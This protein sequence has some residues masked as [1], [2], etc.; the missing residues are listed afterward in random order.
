MIITHFVAKISLTYNGGF[1]IFLLPECNFLSINYQNLFWRISWKSCSTRNQ[2]PSSACRQDPTT[3]PASSWK[4]SSGGYLGRIFGINPRS[5]DLH[6]DGIKMYKDVGE[7][8]VIPD[9]VF[10]LIPARFIPD[11]IDSCGKAGVKWMAILSGGFNETGEEGKKLSDLVLQ[12]ARQYGI[13]FVGPN[14]VTVANTANG[15]CLPFVPSFSPPKGGC[16][17]SPR[18][19]V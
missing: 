3:S 18:A 8:P 5:S 2:S 7:L 11:A 13:R 4:T 12:K 14:G 16:R 9:L 10:I 1:P 17:S 15:L 19:A 6:V